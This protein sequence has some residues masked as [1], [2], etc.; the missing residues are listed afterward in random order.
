MIDQSYRE[1]MR[2]G[3]QNKLRSLVI[4]AIICENSIEPNQDLPKIVCNPDKPCTSTGYICPINKLTV[5]RPFL[6]MQA[7]R[8]LFT[9]HAPRRRRLFSSSGEFALCSESPRGSTLKKPLLTRVRGLRKLSFGQGK[10]ERTVIL[11]ARRWLKVY[12]SSIRRIKELVS[13]SPKAMS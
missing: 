3:H 4:L 5:L 1:F 6:S 13:H 2:S 9:V 11:E 7:N 10:S 8:H 12:L